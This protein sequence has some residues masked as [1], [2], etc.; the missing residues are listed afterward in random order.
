[1]TPNIADTTYR[2]A[3]FGC[4]ALTTLTFTRRKWLR[5]FLCVSH[6]NHGCGP[7][8]AL[9]KGGVCVREPAISS[10]SCGRD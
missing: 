6:D 4:L 5:V 8:R 3:I 2:I 10:V 7:P 9:F 1:M